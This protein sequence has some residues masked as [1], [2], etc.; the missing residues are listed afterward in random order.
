M[1]SVVQQDMEAE[2]LAAA[3]ANAARN[4]QA[5]VGLLAPAAPTI[6]TENS[7]VA[8]VTV[9]HTQRGYIEPEPDKNRIVSRSTEARG[10]GWSVQLGAYSTRFKAQK[11][12]LR[13]ALADLGSLEGAHKKI[14]GAN[15]DGR[16]LY[17]ARFIGVSEV[18][19]RKACSRLKARNQ[20]CA[21]I[22]PGS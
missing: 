1:A 20:P 11:T 13:T 5:N 16:H 9:A 15:V 22:P 8:A 10:G 7:I 6:D 4:A 3:Q 19:A 18:S 14:I 2:I 17:R 21:I 12:L